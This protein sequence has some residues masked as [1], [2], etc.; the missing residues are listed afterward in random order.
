MS[1]SVAGRIRWQHLMWFT[2]VR[3][4]IIAGQQLPCIYKWLTDIFFLSEL[5]FCPPYAA[6]IVRCHV[7]LHF[8]PVWTWDQ[9]CTNHGHRAPSSSQPGWTWVLRAQSDSTH[10]GLKNPI[11]DLTFIMSK[12]PLNIHFF[13]E[14]MAL[15]VPSI[16]YV[17]TFCSH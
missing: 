8:S 10:I 13:P 1:W 17:V 16:G 14:I 12:G 9:P 3:C 5:Y 6:A 2:R 11:K 15:K 4:E 7:K